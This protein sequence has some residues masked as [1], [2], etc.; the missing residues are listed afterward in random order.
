MR[1]SSFLIT[2]FLILNSC[3]FGKKGIDVSIKNDTNLTIYNVSISAG[4]NSEVSFDSISPNE[5]LIKFLDMDNIDRVDG[6]Y[7]LNYTFPDGEN[8]EN[9]F[10][11][12]TNGWPNNYLICC[13][14][15]DSV[16]STMFDEL[17]D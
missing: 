13:S 17:C 4:I 15:N 12:Y 5:T 7:L 6:S 2:F 3:G 11:Y 1:Y 9:S 10:G 14:I 16:I 8:F